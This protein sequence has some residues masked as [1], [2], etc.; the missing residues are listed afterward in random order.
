MPVGVGDVVVVERLGVVGID[1]DMGGKCMELIEV[2]D[3]DFLL[4]S[5]NEWGCY[6][7]MAGVATY[8]LS[9][10]TGFDAVFKT[11]WIWNGRQRLKDDRPL[12]P[13]ARL[14]DDDMEL[15]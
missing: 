3:L 5:E 12:P 13:A 6:P 7:G 11:R 10:R 4:T 2:F 9:T 15:A 1:P 8:Q 14:V